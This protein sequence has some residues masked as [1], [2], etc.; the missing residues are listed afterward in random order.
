MNGLGYFVNDR[1]VNVLVR[2]NLITAY[3]LL[4]IFLL[5]VYSEKFFVL[6]SF[7][8]Q[9]KIIIGGLI[10]AWVLWHTVNYLVAKN[11]IKTNK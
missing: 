1:N 6:P 2:N 10:F 8:E 5:V 11:I 4:A 3:T 9:F 7:I